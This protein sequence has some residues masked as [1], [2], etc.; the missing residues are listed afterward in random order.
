MTNVFSQYGSSAQDVTVQL[1]GPRLLM[2][3]TQRARTALGKVTLTFASA[4]GF[5]T[6]QYITVA[7][8][9]GATPAAGYVGNWV[10]DSAVGTTGSGGTYTV[11]YYSATLSAETI[12]T[13]LTFAVSA[14][15][16]LGPPQR[17]LTANRAIDGAGVVTLTLGHATATGQPFLPGMY[18]T[19]SGVTEGGGRAYNGTWLLT[20]VPDTSTIKYLST[21]VGVSE[22]ATSDTGG[23]VILCPLSSSQILVSDELTADVISSDIVL[24]IT[25]YPFRQTLAWWVGAMF[26]AAGIPS[27][28]RQVEIPQWAI[29]QVI[30][31][32]DLAGKD[33]GSAL[34]ELATASGCVLYYSAPTWYFQARE[35]VRPDLTTVYALDSTLVEWTPAASWEWGYDCVV[36]KGADG[37]VVTRGRNLLAGRTLEVSADLVS[38]YPWLRQVADELFRYF[39]GTR[40][41]GTAIVAAG[42][43]SAGQHIYKL[44]DRVSVAGVEYWV[45]KVSEPIAAY[46]QSAHQVTL[47]A[48]AA[49]PLAVPYTWLNFHGAGYAIGP[50]ACDLN[51]GDWT[52]ELWAQVDSWSANGKLIAKQPGDGTTGWG[53]YHDGG[54]SISFYWFGGNPSYNN[55]VIGI[56]AGQP[57]HLAVTYN[58]TAHVRSFYLNGALIST[59]TGVTPPTLATS[60]IMFGADANSGNN[61]HARIR[62]VR[63]WNTCRSAADVLY[64][65][66][67]PISLT[68]FASQLT[69]WWRCQEGWGGT[70]IDQSANGY[71]CTIYGARWTFPVG[72]VTSTDIKPEPST[73]VPPIVTTASIDR[74]VQVDV[75]EPASNIAGFLVTTW[76]AISARD[77]S[78]AIAALNPFS[79][80]VDSNGWIVPDRYAVRY[81]PAMSP[82]ADVQI[83]CCDGRVSDPSDPFLSPA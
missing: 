63:M 80:V 15:P 12:Q 41:R 44:G 33:V 42:L 14:A 68:T 31:Y 52:I 69:A 40:A 64:Y 29:S 45:T 34:V 37:K 76:D 23:R 60:P 24:P 50:A 59:T 3:T 58:A 70:L 46:E 81:T 73:V 78:T 21:S 77:S 72:D 25:V 39:G 1:I 22:G 51:A 57:F 4:H 79:F 17:F 26:D 49:I 32:W 8:P 66:D 43:A 18:V 16:L 5:S 11:S 61:A 47:E 71:N 48:V 36:V 27:G 7:A 28:S 20:A 56:P 9:V 74:T 53:I 65:K 54:E 83:V 6:G 38:T 2:V 67:V 30:P 62:T 55:L 10:V 82:N 19:V 35:L 13:E 75:R